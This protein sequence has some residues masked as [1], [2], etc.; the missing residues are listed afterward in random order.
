MPT[1]GTNAEQAGF[2]YLAIVP[3]MQAALLL[4]VLWSW[5]WALQSL[6][7]LW[8]QEHKVQNHNTKS[9]KH[10]KGYLS[11]VTDSHCSHKI[12]TSVKGTS[13]DKLPIVLT[14]P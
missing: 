13:Q 10:R 1:V 14:N 9:I 11:A 5:A 3:A 7:W 2:L 8:E 6:L 12:K 4:S